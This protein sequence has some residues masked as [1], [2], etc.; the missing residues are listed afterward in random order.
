[1]Y[2]HRHELKSAQIVDRLVSHFDDR[3][4]EPIFKHI[5]DSKT[6]RHGR[7]HKNRNENSRRRRICCAFVLDSR[8]RCC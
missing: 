3:R 4:V 6:K 5:R 7:S 1:M 2:N 8:A